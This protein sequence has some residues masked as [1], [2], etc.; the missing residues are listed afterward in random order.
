MCIY[1]SNISKMDNDSKNTLKG[2]AEWLQTKR[3]WSDYEALTSRGC[4]S[5]TEK[6]WASKEALQS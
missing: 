2:V 4:I 1:W 6:A 3:Y 5:R